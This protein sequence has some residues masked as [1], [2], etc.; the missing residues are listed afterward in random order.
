MT[1][2]SPTYDVVLLDLDGTLID[3]EPGVQAALRHAITTGFGIVPTQAQLEEFMGPPL[4]EVLPRV[5]GLSDPADEQRFF[6]LYCDV[7]FHGTEYEFDV[8]PGMSSLIADLQEAG[9]RVCLATAK[10]D[11]SAARILEHADLLQHFEFIGGSH[12]DGSRQDK[13]EVLEHTLRSIDADSERHRIV[14]VG[15]RAL[16]VRAAEAHGIDSIAVTWGYA[17]DGELDAAG[18]THLVS[19]VTQLRALLLP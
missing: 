11:E 9:S 12:I 6:E 17:P 18:S 19:D 4:A 8:Y 2:V 16:D 1:D 3:S 5:F 7:Y 10:P 13:V 14:L 15:D